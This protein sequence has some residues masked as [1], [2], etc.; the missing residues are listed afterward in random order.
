VGLGDPDR[1]ARA[2]A[3]G[4][5]SAIVIGWWLLSTRAVRMPQLLGALAGAGGAGGAAGTADDEPRSDPKTRI[6]GV[7]RFAKTR[8]SNANRLR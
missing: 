7:G 1:G 5:A 3:L 8:T 6:G 2:A 4:G